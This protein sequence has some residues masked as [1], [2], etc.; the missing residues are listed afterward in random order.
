MQ[1]KCQLLS[2][3]VANENGFR[4]DLRKCYADRRKEM[5]LAPGFPR[6]SCANSVM[7]IA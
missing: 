7:M 2:E 5:G 1:S 6:R 4:G 3:I